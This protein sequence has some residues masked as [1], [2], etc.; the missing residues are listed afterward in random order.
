MTVQFEDVD[1][2]ET[3]PG[4]QAGADPPAEPADASAPP[5]AP[6]PVPSEAI[7]PLPFIPLGEHVESVEELTENV[8]FVRRRIVHR[9]DPD[10]QVRTPDSIIRELDELK[11]AAGLMPLVLRNAANARA[12]N[13][14]RA[15][16]ARAL[17]AS[18]A[19]GRDAKSRE[20]QVEAMAA[21]QIEAADD[22]EIVYQ[23]ARDVA[24]VIR[25]ST[26]AVQTQAKQV[27][28]TYQ[29]AGRGER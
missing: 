16:K 22:A 26:S 19:S 5:P 3:A 12:A 1:A 9:P 10:T 24:Q 15:A 14:R 28:I 23:Y 13:R 7:E 21:A 18:R 17:A 2:P 20:L 4:L 27:E 25:D 6:G 8:E 11:Y 29:L